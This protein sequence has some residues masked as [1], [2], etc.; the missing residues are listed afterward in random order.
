V[1]LQAFGSKRLS[2]ASGQVLYD[3]GMGTGKILVQA[4]LQFKNLK[5]VYGVEMSAGRY[6]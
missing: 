4:F 3:L 5:Y 1:Q 6:K 2:A